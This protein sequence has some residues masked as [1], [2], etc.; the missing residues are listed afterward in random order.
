MLA[1]RIRIPTQLRERPAAQKV[2][3]SRPKVAACYGV[4]VGFGIGAARE[5]PFPLCAFGV[6]GLLDLPESPI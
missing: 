5:V 1:G 2:P 3:N 4:E 6:L